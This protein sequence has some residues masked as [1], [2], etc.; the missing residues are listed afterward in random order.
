MLKWLIIFIFT[1]VIIVS[2][3]FYKKR[4]YESYEIKNIYFNIKE[5]IK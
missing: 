2:I 3:Y 4:D 1:I 5:R